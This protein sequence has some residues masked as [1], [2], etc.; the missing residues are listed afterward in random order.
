MKPL[1]NSVDYIDP[2]IFHQEQEDIFLP[3]WLFVGYTSDLQGEDGWFQFNLFDKSYFIQK[4]G[5][6][7]HCFANTCPHRHA[8]LRTASCGNS[9]ITCPYHGWMFHQN[10]SIK[11]IP[12]KPRFC[13]VTENDLNDLKLRSYPV[14]V[15]GT[16]IFVQLKANEDSSWDKFIAPIKSTV[17]PLIASMGT[18][19]RRVQKTIQANWK[20]I[21]ENS[22]EGYHLDCVH[23][24]TFAKLNL[25]TPNM[26]THPPHC[27]SYAPVDSSALKRWHRVEHLFAS[28]MYKSNSYDHAIIFPNL[29]IG[30][31][32]GSTIAIEQYLPL[33]STETLYTMDLFGCNVKNSSPHLDSTREAFFENSFA[34]AKLIFNEDVTIAETQQRGMK[35]ACHHG[36]LSEDEALIHF[37]QKMWRNPAAL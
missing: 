4:D 30:S 12:R 3:S 28:R 14:A 16:L 26:E 7:I 35:S 19:R 13:D 9:P 31:L 22:V 20:I 36:R 37:L 6:A 17:D 2:I 27:I 15:W 11:A 23:P 24:T 33:N 10:G 29:G 21:I 1:L 34:F 8:E 5:D 25:A 18:F 32:Y